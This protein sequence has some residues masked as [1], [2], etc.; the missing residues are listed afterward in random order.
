MIMPKPFRS[1]VAPIPK[2]NIRDT[3]KNMRKATPSLVLCRAA[4]IPKTTAASTRNAKY[5]SP[6]YVPAI[7]MA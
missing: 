3:F 7:K 5:C 4:K 2:K 6:K 1:N